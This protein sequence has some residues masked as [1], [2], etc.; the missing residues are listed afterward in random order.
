MRRRFMGKNFLKLLTLLLLIT[1]LISCGEKKEETAYEKS[2]AKQKMKIKVGVEGDYPPYT[3]TDEKGKMTGYDV[4]VMEEIAKRRN[5]DVEFVVTPWDGIFLALESGKFDLITNLSKTSEREEKY[6]FTDDYLI[7]GAQ[8]IVKKGRKDI[9]SMN[10]F[11]GKKIMTSVGSN[12]NQIMT[13]YDK[14]KEF[15]LTYYDG[16]VT[17]AFDEIAQGRADATINDRLTA[18]YFVKQKGDIIEVVGEVIDK[19]PSYMIVRK[20]DEKLK[21]EI[22]EGLK[23]IKA[24][25]TLVKISEKWFGADYTK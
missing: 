14:N 15:K 10:D 2:P 6:D 17:V 18:G 20:G 23:E 5:I 4:E 1:F 21:N 19:S 3:F 25:G 13:D 22:N 8:I 11:K 9:Q 24:D 7:S 12:Y 16:E